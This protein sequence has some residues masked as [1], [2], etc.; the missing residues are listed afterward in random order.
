[1]NSCDNKDLV[2]HIPLTLPRIEVEL[3]VTIPIVPVE[4]VANGSME[5]KIV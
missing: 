5:A 3:T 2:V 4:N 1:M